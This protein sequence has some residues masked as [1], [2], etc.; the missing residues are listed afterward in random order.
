MTG[1]RWSWKGALITGFSIWLLLLCG[2]C[3]ASSKCML[4]VTLLGVLVMVSWIA[5]GSTGVSLGTLNSLIPKS[6]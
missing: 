6:Q 4:N 1:D 2:F 5:G 3:G